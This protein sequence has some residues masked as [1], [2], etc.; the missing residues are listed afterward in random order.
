MIFMLSG[1]Y[2]QNTSNHSKSG[3][4]G[5]K[6]ILFLAETQEIPTMDVTKAT[7]TVSAHILGNVMEGL[8]RLDKENKLV[9]GMAESYNISPDRKKYT[10]HIRKSAKWS[11]GD[12]V[13]AKDFVFAWQRLV[14]P[15]T[16]AEYAFIAYPIK[17]AKA[18]HE[19]GSM[20]Q[21]LGA[22]VI[23]DYTLEVELE[24]PVPYFLNLTAFPSF[25]PI[26]EKVVTD[27]GD[28]YGLEAATVVYNGPFTMTEWKHEQ[29]WTLQKNKHYWD[30]QAVKLE[31]IH[32]NV[33]KEPSTLI[34]LYDS[35]QLDRALLTSDFTDKYKGRKDEFGTYLEASTTFLQLN[36][37][38]NQQDTLF[39]NKKIREAIALTIDKKQLAGILLNDGSIPV[40]YFVP[41]GFTQGPDGKDFRTSFHNG[42]QY[43]VAKA[44]QLWK[45]GKQEVKKK[46]WTIELLNYD[47]GNQKKIGEYIKEQLEKNLEGITVKLKPIPFKQKLKLESD[48][49]FDCSIAAWQPDY[50]DP[51]SFID[52]FE[53]KNSLNNINY[54]NPTYDGIIKN[55][56]I[57]DN[58]TR[59]GNLGQAEK[60]LLEGDVA[61]VPLFQH[62]Q[63]YVQRPNVH[64]VYHH[65]ISP[66]YSYKWA[67][68][69]EK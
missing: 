40:N 47:T 26:N 38:R 49:D 56:W 50:A 60:I 24:N 42:L 45:E 23:D 69:T 64:N 61:I 1:C 30:K 43:N 8:Y 55:E 3:N 53:T 52:M 28:T 25:Y 14:D 22:K 5:S 29:G 63:S 33:V 59:W 19:G 41:K 7:D 11:N 16:A 15:A 51:M 58:Q 36:Q 54:T 21:S 39:K 9:P 6:Q 34:N 35:G 62:G 65:M 27:R 2:K 12:T 18:I 32:F 57:V 68:I 4:F 37:K 20:T 67:Y 44:K 13:T 48:K 10:F 46:Q 17:N 31:K 66:M